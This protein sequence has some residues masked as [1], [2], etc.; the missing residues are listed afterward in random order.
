MAQV[1]RQHLRKEGIK[2]DVKL[3]RGQVLSPGNGRDLPDK[4]LAGWERSNLGDI[5][6]FLSVLTL[7][8]SRWPGLG[9][10]TSLCPTTAVG[11]P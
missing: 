8:L 2:S 5:K 10:S 9:H 1:A 4:T 3:P 11:T 6:V 7:P